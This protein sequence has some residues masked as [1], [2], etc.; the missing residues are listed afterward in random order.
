MSCTRAIE[1]RI[2]AVCPESMVSIG[3]SVA[4]DMAARCR[5]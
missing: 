2:Q 5:G 4:L 3:V 1:M